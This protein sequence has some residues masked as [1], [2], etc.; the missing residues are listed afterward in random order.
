MT[1]QLTLRIALELAEQEA[2]VREMYFDNAKPPVATWSIGI[3]DASGHHVER[4]KDNPQPIERCLEVYVWLLG[5]KY[6]PEVL[7]AFAGRTL[8]ETQLAAA[9]SFHYNT[10]AIARAEWVKAYR[11]G[12]MA[13]ARHLLET[14]FL[15]GGALTKRRAAEAELLFDGKWAQTGKITVWPVKKPGYTP[16]WAHPQRVDITSDMAKA[17]AA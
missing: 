14:N 7:A 3:T 5:A 1:D 2:L 8:S 13:G 9:L 17:L 12:D 15:N 11:R 16:D 6:L 4:Y 10:G